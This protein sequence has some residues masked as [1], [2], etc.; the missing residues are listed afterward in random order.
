[1][2][3]MLLLA[4]MYVFSNYIKP[5]KIQS[6]DKHCNKELMILI[7]C[8]SVTKLYIRILTMALLSFC[9]ESSDSSGAFII[10]SMEND[11]NRY[12]H[13]NQVSFL[14]ACFCWILFCIVL[15]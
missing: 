15:V 10:K 3:L 7:H 14:D 6:S 4:P 2:L 11:S 8:S 1:M 13:V 12:L 5:S 9:L